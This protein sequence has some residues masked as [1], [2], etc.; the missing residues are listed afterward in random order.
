MNQYVTGAVIR[1]LRES[2]KLTQAELAESLCITDKTVSKWETGKGYPD[3]TMLEPLAAALGISV[4]ELLRGSEITNR[5]RACNMKK[6]KFYVCPMCGNVIWSAGEAVISCCGITLPPLES[7]IPEEAH[8]PEI[9]HVEDEYYVTIPHE[10]TKQH[11][12]S[13]LAAVSDNGCEIV[14]LYPEGAAEARFKRS[15]AYA[16]YLYCNRHG[17]FRVPIRPLRR[18][19]N[20]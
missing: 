10:M 7:E 19:N 2:K 11:Y 9:T 8:T 14:K 17:L 4:T 12:L 1:K 20:I 18:K 6:M 13:F 3:I 16:I 15:R 5:N